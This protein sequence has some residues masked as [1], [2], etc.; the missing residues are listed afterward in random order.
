MNE[1]SLNAHRPVSANGPRR[2]F[3]RLG[4]SAKAAN[5]LNTVQPF[6]AYRDGGGQLHK[7]S[8]PA[9]KR[10][11][12]KMTVVVIQERVAELQEFYADELEPFLFKAR[13]DLAYKSPLNRVGLD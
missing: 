12:R 8:D 2:G 11:L 7:P 3:T 10:L 1:V 13:D 9:K 4:Y 6:E 5:G